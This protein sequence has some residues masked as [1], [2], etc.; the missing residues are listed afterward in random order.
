M[1]QQDHPHAVALARLIAGEEPTGET[2][3]VVRHLLS[4]CLTCAAELRRLVK[5][6]T[7]SSSPAPE[8]VNEV[9]EALSRAARAVRERAS[10]GSGQIDAVYK[11]ARLLLSQ[12]PLRQELLLKN[13]ARG[14]SWAL[15]ELLLETSFS[16]R[17]ENPR[18]MVELA[19]LAFRTAAGLDPKEFGPRAVVDLEARAAA[20]LANALRVA[21]DDDSSLQA[22]LAAFR[23]S[24]FGTGDSALKARIFEVAALVF[25]RRRMQE[26]AAKLLQRSFS[27]YRRAGETQRAGRVL[28]SWGVLESQR[29]DPRACLEKLSQASE[30][31]DLSEDSPLAL[32]VVHNMLFALVDLERYEAAAEMLEECRH[33]YATDTHRLT[34]LR[35]TWLEARI[36]G[37]LGLE[38]EAEVKLL[39]V[40]HGFHLH[41]C[42]HEAALARLDLALLLARQ[43]RLPELESL[44]QEM[45]VS[46]E[47]QGYE[48]EAIAA[49]L[50]LKQALRRPQAPAAIIGKVRQ[51]LI[52]LPNQ[53]GLHFEA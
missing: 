42:A 23:L 31:L 26:L 17:F 39:E 4:G 24:S 7:A 19:E 3:D 32:S 28:V 10:P 50:V 37:G 33:L 38:I 29:P 1:D 25:R 15:A 46:F 11:F 34:T 43:N 36:A 47:A 5:G 45:V 16:L 30:M 21:G 9:E 51:F 41:G 44:T 40:A 20:E 48:Q 2:R 6:F 13:S 53:R 49:L 52:R 27:L 18:R 12:P 35:L 22:L 8:E 14:R